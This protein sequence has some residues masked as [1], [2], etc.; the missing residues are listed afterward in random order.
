MQTLPDYRPLHR[1]ALDVA[2]AVIANVGPQD[3][4]RPTP[5]T[6]WDLGTLLAHCIGQNHGFADA[7]D[8][9][10]A[11][12]GAFAHRTFP[13]DGLTDAWSHSTDRLSSAFA[14]APLD[15]HVR[16]AEI[17]PDTTFPVAMVVGF[18][19]LDT[20]IHTWDIA[21]A[22]GTKFR[23]D[24]EL[25]DATLSQARLVPGAPAVREGPGAVFAPVL[26]SDGADPWEESLALL[27]RTGT[28][29]P[30]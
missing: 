15:R 26:P 6:A 5:C 4:T 13:A 25:V 2:G 27:G 23:P 1:R 8:N 10:D 17:R 11:P 21:T 22:L 19:R 30:G 9:G 24:D 7:V 3:L 16:L 20:V 28:V 12:A 18:Q 14:A 29:G